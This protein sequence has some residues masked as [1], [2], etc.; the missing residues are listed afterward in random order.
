LKLT[1][2]HRGFAVVTAANPAIEN[3]GFVGESK[4]RILDRLRGGGDLVAK[5]AVLRASDS[6]EDRIAAVRRF[7]QENAL[8]LPLVLKPDVGQRGS[9]VQ[10][11]RDEDS[12]ARFLKD[13]M[14][15]DHV[16]QEYVPGVEYGIFYIRHPNEA[17]GRIF[18]IT[19]KKMPIVVG[20]GERSIEDLILSDERAVCAAS[21]YFE[22]NR[23]RL[24]DVPAMG[25]RIQ[26]V[27]LGTHCRGAIFLD[28][29]AIKTPQLEAAIERLSRSFD[30]FYFGR[31]DVRGPSVE[32]FLRGEGIKVIE[33]NGVTSEATHVY[34]PKHG[35]KEA[36]RVLFEQWRIAFAIGAH[37]AALGAETTSLFAL[38][39]RFFAYRR[40][41]R[42]HAAN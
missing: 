33:L 38:L 26:L 14:T 8:E 39:R 41:Q 4:A 7:R 29:A 30:G 20:D 18:S 9:G 24:S 19:E 23:D 27:E 12:L 5:S 6:P 22:R 28:G 32:H 42:R 34:D 40:E 31:Y 1:W 21:T 15:L 10:I 25:E 37:N 17:R 11:V 13:E 36:Y 2:K 16:V 35:L 3:G